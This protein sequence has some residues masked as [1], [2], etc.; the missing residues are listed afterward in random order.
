M[1]HRRFNIVLFSDS[2]IK[3]YTFCERTCAGA[4]FGGYSV[5]VSADHEW[6]FIYLR[7]SYIKYKQ[8]STLSG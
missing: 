6:N 7:A 8:Q 4:Q 3:L 2:I 5:V 1:A